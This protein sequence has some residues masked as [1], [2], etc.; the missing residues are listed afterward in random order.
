M[1]LLS[2]ALFLLVCLMF[3]HQLCP[4]S[5]PPSPS[6]A[7]EHHLFHVIRLPTVL[8][9]PYVFS[10]LGPGQIGSDLFVLPTQPG[11]GLNVCPRHLLMRFPNPSAR[12]PILFVK[13]LLCTLLSVSVIS[14]VQGGVLAL[15]SIASG[16][17][18]L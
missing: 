5:I 2:L 18:V 7:F 12:L 4:T 9:I 3:E 15:I 13:L 6:W 16:N 14:T 10:G 8:T 11:E 17:I 1:L